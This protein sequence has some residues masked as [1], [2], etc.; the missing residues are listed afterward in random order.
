MRPRPHVFLFIAGLSLWSSCF[1]LRC[2]A[3]LYLLRF[4]LKNPL[5]GFKLWGDVASFYAAATTAK[6]KQEW[7]TQIL[8]V[9]VDNGIAK[10]ERPPN[11]HDA[12]PPKA[13]SRFDYQ[14]DD[15]FRF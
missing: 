1:A 13:V 14:S 5:C 2:F 15:V 11:G 12:S 8:N 10:V 6:A 9:L 3:L 7:L 4:T